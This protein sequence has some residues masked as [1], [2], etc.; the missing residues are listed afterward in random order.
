MDPAPN[1]PSPDSRPGTTVATT[2]V[3]PVLPTWDA[4]YQ[5]AARRRRAAGGRDN[6]RVIKRRRLLRERL[7]FGLGVLLAGALTLVFYLVLR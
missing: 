7:G 1:A 6:F 3:S 4:Y 5:E 2:G